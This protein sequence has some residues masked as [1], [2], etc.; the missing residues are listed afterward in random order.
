[1]SKRPSAVDDRLFVREPLRHYRRTYSHAEV[2]W[3]LV[4]LCAL[5]AVAVWVVWRGQNP[6]PTLFAASDPNASMELPGA[7]KKAPASRGPLPGDIA[8]DGWTEGAVSSFDP[9]NLYVKIDGRAD[10]FLSYGF[11]NLYFLTLRGPGD[12]DDAPVIDIECYELSSSENAVGAF[13]G[14][15]KDGEPDSSGG[16]LAFLSS[17]ALFLA[18]D[19]Y[20][21]RA[22][23][24]DDSEAIR[25]A[26][27]EIR[28]SLESAIAGGAR[29]WSHELLHGQLGIPIDAISYAAE[30]AF[31]F[32]FAADVYSALAEGDVQ[33]FV[34]RRADEA[35][36]R[37]FAARLREGFATLG[38]AQGDWIKDK[39]I[40]TYT[41]AAAEGRYM[42][43]VRNAPDKAAGEAWLA[44]LREALGAA[45]E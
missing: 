20:Y 10:Y 25:S 32:E 21:I 41:T 9:Q 8:P 31:S 5:A 3:G 13:G 30:N 27:A 34:A 40:G 28:G 44:R 12:A 1:M 19:V 29:P 24:S 33:L 39:F 35:A 2:R 23:G 14:E 37:D 36:A 26:L 18:R 45:N 38:T 43:G 22:I 15:R 6:D 11:E 16:G 42:I 4:V 17:N 7:E